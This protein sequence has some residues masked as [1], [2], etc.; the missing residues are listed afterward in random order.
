MKV[1]CSQRSRSQATSLLVPPGQRPQGRAHGRPPGLRA[2]SLLP[3]RELQAA[4]RHPDP[5]GRWGYAGPLGPGSRL[6]AFLPQTRHT[7]PPPAS[8]PHCASHPG[9]PCRPSSPA[10]P[11]SLLRPSEVD[12]VPSVSSG[13]LGHRKGISENPLLPASTY[14]T[15]SAAAT[16]RPH[17]HNAFAVSSRRAVPAGL[18]SRAWPGRCV[19]ARLP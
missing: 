19:T 13:C 6:P 7:D 2:A 15:H 9:G 12:P 4:P 8:R 16:R 10:T 17:P 5:P 11:A 14:F 18:P 1:S 3:V